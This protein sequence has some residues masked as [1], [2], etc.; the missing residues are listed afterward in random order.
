MMRLIYW[1]VIEFASVIYKASA[2]SKRCMLLLCTSRGIPK[3]RVQLE[4]YREKK[5]NEE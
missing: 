5:T 4:I 1:K 3:D 2:G